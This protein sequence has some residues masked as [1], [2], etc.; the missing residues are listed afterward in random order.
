MANRKAT[1][2]SILEP[3]AG[4]DEVT[5]LADYESDKTFV[6]GRYGVDGTYKNPATTFEF[7]DANKKITITTINTEWVQPE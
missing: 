3:L 4:T 7:D 5:K 2:L 1:S 6:E